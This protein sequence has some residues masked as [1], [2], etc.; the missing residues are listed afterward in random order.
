MGRV[1]HVNWVVSDDGS[2]GGV[3]ADHCLCT[4][5]TAQFQEGL[6]GVGVGE[7]KNIDLPLVHKIKDPCRDHNSPGIAGDFARLAVFFSCCTLNPG[8]ST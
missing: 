4:L 5:L 1:L 3:V 7:Q 8:T 2:D 6:Q